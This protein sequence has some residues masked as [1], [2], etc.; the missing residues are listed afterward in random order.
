MGST[1]AAVLPVPVGAQPMM[2]LPAIA[3]GIAFLWISVGVAYPELETLC[4]I[5]SDKPIVEKLITFL[6]GNMIVVTR[7]F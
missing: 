6:L 1:N 7:Y 5:A 2:S 4:R 3:G